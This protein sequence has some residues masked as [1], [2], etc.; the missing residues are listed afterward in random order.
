M[1]SS[2]ENLGRHALHFS[3]FPEAMIL[4]LSR[5]SV[6]LRR[7][8]V[9]NEFVAVLCVL[10]LVSCARLAQVLTL[11]ALPLALRNRDAALHAQAALIPISITARCWALDLRL[12]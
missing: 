6:A 3:C 10:A 5:T 7:T 4:Q 12:R 2:R 1:A 9:T 11:S 8:I